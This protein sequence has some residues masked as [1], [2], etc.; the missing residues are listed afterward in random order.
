MGARDLDRVQ[1][2]VLDHE[3]VALADLVA[4]AL[5]LGSHR[6]AGFLIDELL[7]KSI[8]GGL[9]DLPESDAL[10]ARARRMQRDRARDQC[11]FE[12]AFPVRTHGVTRW[13]GFKERMPFPSAGGASF[14]RSGA[15]DMAVTGRAVT[16]QSLAPFWIGRLIGA[17]DWRRQLRSSERKTGG[18]SRPCR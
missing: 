6:L 7:A 3:V 2:R 15:W 4:A 18:R 8:A 14:S 17:W 10:Q 16:A 5:V 12:I 11:Q 13:F 9:V 1:F